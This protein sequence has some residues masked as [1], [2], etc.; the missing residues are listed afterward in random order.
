MSNIIQIL[1]DLLFTKSFLL[2][3]AF[4]V[5]MFSPYIFGNDNL[6]E[7]MAEMFIEE[8]TGQQ[9]DFTPQELR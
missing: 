5:G 7:Q 8:T 1:K 6:A 3:L 4:A 9:I 2:G